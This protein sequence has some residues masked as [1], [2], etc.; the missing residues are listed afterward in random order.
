LIDIFHQRGS[1][2]RAIFDFR[3]S[4]RHSRRLTTAHPFAEVNH[5]IALIFISHKKAQKTQK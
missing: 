2:F 5:H 4:A 3:D 1:A